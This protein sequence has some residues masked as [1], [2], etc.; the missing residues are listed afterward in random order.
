[1]AVQVAQQVRLEVGAGRHFH[2][3]ED[4]RQ[5]KVVVHRRF[6][7]DEFKQTPEQ[8]FQSQIRAQAFVERVLVKN[9]AGGIPVC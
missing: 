6:A 8:L 4:R 9:H 2:D 7:R 1:V 3:L 5:G